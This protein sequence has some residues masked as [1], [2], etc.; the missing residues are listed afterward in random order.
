MVEKDLSGILATASIP[1]L[2]IASSGLEAYLE[3]LAPN[4][5][6]DL[7]TVKLDSSIVIDNGDTNTGGVW[8]SI[9]RV[10]TKAKRY[11]NLDLSDC[12]FNDNIISGSLLTDSLNYASPESVTLFFTSPS[13]STGSSN[14]SMPN[15]MNVISENIFIRGITLPASVITIGV[16]AFCNCKFLESVII[17]ASV[18]NIG[19]WAFFGCVRLKSVTIPSSITN[20]GDKAFSDCN[21]LKSVTIPVT[22]CDTIKSQFSGYASLSVV[23]TGGG[24]IPSFAFSGC[25]GL[26]SVII[27]ERVKS[28]GS[29]AFSGCSGLKSITIPNKHAGIY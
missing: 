12:R 25:S 24:N 20:I 7:Y 8:A 22:L 14:S 17:P 1:S 10:I 6:A 26:K 29:K 19:D 9:N 28:I 11:V 2:S 3:S 23:L 18:T 16:Y 27:P 5:T 4:T 15:A 21:G 13:S